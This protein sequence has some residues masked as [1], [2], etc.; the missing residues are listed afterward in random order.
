MGSETMK[1]AFG[2]I[3]DME[4][5]EDAELLNRLAAAHTAIRMINRE[6]KNNVDIM[7]KQAQIEVLKEP[8]KQRIQFQKQIVSAAE[9]IAQSRN[10][11][12]EEKQ[13]NDDES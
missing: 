10:I 8:Y 6:I 4:D 1:A 2:N 12:K 3:N 13:F 11:L 9:V 5:L 7:Q